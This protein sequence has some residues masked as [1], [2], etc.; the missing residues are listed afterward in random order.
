MKKIIAILVALAV[1]SMAFAQTVS[2][3]NVLET[4]P[5][6]V[7]NGGAAAWTW[8]AERNDG[9]FLKDTINAEAETADGRGKAKAN[10]SSTLRVVDAAGAGLLNILPR[11]GITSPEAQAAG[12]YKATDFL[13][14][15]FGSLNSYM[16]QYA[17]GGYGGTVQDMPGPNGGRENASALLPGWTAWNSSNFCNGAFV[18]FIGDGVGL[19]G[20]KASLIFDNDW[21]NKNT[22]S[23]AVQVGYDAA[24]FG[25]TAK[26]EGTFG[27]QGAG[28]TAY[29]AALTVPYGWLTDKSNY[30]HDFTVGVKYRGLK[31]LAVGTTLG[32]AFDVRA[33]KVNKTYTA[34]G[35]GL[36]ADFDFRNDITDRLWAKVGF[37]QDE[38]GDSVK[39]LPFAV[40]TELTY[41]IGGE[42]DAKFIF[43][44][45]YGQSALARKLKEADGKRTAASTN[46]I[47]IYP[48]FEFGF[49][50]SKFLFGVKNDVAGH[51]EYVDKTDNDWAYTKLFGDQVRVEIPIKWTYT[52]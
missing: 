33:R 43:E 41:A 48:S 4:R 40:G 13:A 14:F 47:Y 15:G 32:A 45:A 22:F 44:L 21:L 8:A 11:I 3:N 37:G 17:V 51:L 30:D 6:I 9:A 50:K 46:D 38:N 39:V 52:F 26:Y 27:G 10:V 49:G 34:F 42:H 36:Q 23:F 12:S 18:T 29:T 19:D 5:V 2:M 20:F 24:L 31:D 35:V 16:L 25:A 1:V 7:V 28:N